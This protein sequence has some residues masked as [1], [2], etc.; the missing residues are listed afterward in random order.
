MN[1]F[2]RLL[3][4]ILQSLLKPISR[5]PYFK[6]RLSFRVMPTD[7]DPNLHMTN[8][9][10]LSFMDL[11][12]VDMLFRTNLRGAFL[13]ERWAPT[14][15]SSFIRYRRALPPFIRFDLITDIVDHDEKWIYMEQRI[16]VEGE[17]Y[18]VA[19]FKGLF[20][21]SS[22]NISPEVVIRKLGRELGSGKVTDLPL[23]FYQIEQ[24]RLSLSKS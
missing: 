12:R 6:S 4:V 14:I 11:G 24:A 16:E 22:G 20:R 21:T 13:K 2:V 9:R 7:C 17:L 1:L 15:G 23:V 5:D 18:A 19:Y 10:Y 8:A 3:W